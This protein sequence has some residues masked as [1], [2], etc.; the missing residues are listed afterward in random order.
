M[1]L[2]TAIGVLVAFAGKTSRSALKFPKESD[3]MWSMKTKQ[4]CKKRTETQSQQ[5]AAAIL[6]RI[7][8]PLTL[9]SVIRALIAESKSGDLG[10]L[11]TGDVRPA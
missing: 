6:R 5:T 3:D 10:Q 1:G 9:D 7:S 8:G 11:N 4:Q 2:L